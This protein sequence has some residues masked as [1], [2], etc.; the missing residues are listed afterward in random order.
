MVCMVEIY[1]VEYAPKSLMVLGG[2]KNIRW[3]GRSRAKPW[4]RKLGTQSQ[5][6]WKTL[7]VEYQKC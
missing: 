7:G 6:D 5:K 4:P 1:W 2:R 3:N